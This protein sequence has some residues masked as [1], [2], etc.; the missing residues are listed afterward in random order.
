V[1]RVSHGTRARD[2]GVIP[3]SLRR[4]NKFVSRQ[5]SAL[6]AFTSPTYPFVLALPVPSTLPPSP[7]TPLSPLF[8]SSPL[9][10]LR[11]PLPP[12]SLSLSLSLSRSFL[13]PQSFPFSYLVLFI[14]GE[15]PPA[16]TVGFSDG[17]STSFASP[18]SSPSLSRS[19]RSFLIVSLALPPYQFFV[20]PNTS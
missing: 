3:G 19:A 2:G 12:V 6:D 7:R 14:P 4:E 1:A 11:A 10:Y 18:A 16:T 17:P 15:K 8:F 20:L 9:R 13:Q 5:I